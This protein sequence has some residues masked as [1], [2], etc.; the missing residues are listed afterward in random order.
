MTPGRN[1]AF[2]LAELLMALAILA[3]LLT[4][5]GAAVHASLQSHA[6]NQEAADATQTVR[7]IFP[8][9]TRELRT[10]AAVDAVTDTLVILPPAGSEASEIR[11]R[12]AGGRLYYQRTTAQG[13]EEHVLLDNEGDTSL[14]GVTLTPAYGPDAE[15]TTCT[16]SVRIRVDFEIDGRSHSLVASAAPRRNQLY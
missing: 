4:A 15:G 1:N 2:A 7:V 5:V 8:R 3:V 9:M 10:A 16:K 11:Y 12:Y 6:A 13:T 14:T